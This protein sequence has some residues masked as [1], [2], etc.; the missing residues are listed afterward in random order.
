MSENTMPA[1]IMSQSAPVVRA[2]VDASAT[3]AILVSLSVCHMLNDLNQSL[4][5]ALYP[6]LKQSYHLDFAQIG[7][8]TLAFQLTASMLQPVVG[9][10][11]DR[12]PQPFSL[13]VAMSCSLIG[14]LLLSV[15]DSYPMILL[16]AAL[17]GI[18]SSVFH[19]EASRVA[20]MASGGRYGFAQSL[21]QLGG[22]T[23]SAIG[24]LLA[25]FIVLPRGQGSVAWFS[26][27]AL[28]AIAL[29][30]YVG[31]W[32]NRHPAITARRGRR[33]PPPVATSPLPRATVIMAMSVILILLF[34]KNVYTA[35]LS[36]YYIFYLIDKFHVTVQSAQLH[37]FVFL[38][39]VAIGTFAGGPIGDRIGRK[40]VIWC[41][42]LGILPFTLVL[43]YAN[44]FWTTVLS[45]VIGL[46]LASAFSAI[47][48]YAHDLVP[49]KI[50][51][52]SGLFFGLAFGMAGVGAA[53]MGWL[54]DATSIAFVYRVCSFLPAIGLLTAFLPN[55]ETGYRR[56][57]A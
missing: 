25:A 33:T 44:L 13:P 45:V 37:L 7:L 15:A 34:S 41:S 8:I 16:A 54:A 48:V 46:V 42:I 14:L 21:F 6:I 47:I 29:L 11:T 52:I 51:M 23:G 36:S 30:T 49:G 38:G 57:G 39:A 56:S 35:S 53:I 3:F 9:M 2:P 50:G 40:Y 10:V 1:A 26:L 5:P 22:A 31:A 24:P 18:G 12:R 20:R 32:Y 43:P 19:P 17:V 27:I 28:V 4:V 55:L